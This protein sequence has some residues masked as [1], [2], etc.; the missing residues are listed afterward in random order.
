MAE[1]KSTHEPGK[2]TSMTDEAIQ[3]AFQDLKPASQYTN[4]YH[5]GLAQ[6]HWRLATQHQCHTPLHPQ[7][8]P[9]KPPAL[10]IGRVQKPYAGSHCPTPSLRLSN[11]YKPLLGNKD[12]AGCACLPP[13]DDT[14]Q[15][16]RPEQVIA[17][18][19]NKGDGHQKNHQ[20][21][22]QEGLPDS[23]TSPAY[24]LRPIRSIA[25]PPMRHSPSSKHSM[26]ESW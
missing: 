7:V 25:S 19:C 17:K 18:I 14:L 26:R 20:A 23:L 21:K 22:E 24:R 16:K 13:K 12:L 3:K 2:P 5:A 15:Q 1:C 4:L 10:S 11:L 6:N 8:S 9:I